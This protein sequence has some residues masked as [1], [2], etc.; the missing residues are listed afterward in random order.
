MALQK[1]DRG[2][3]SRRR[4]VWKIDSDLFTEVSPFGHFPES[5]TA[6]PILPG[7]W[8]GRHTGLKILWDVSRAGS[9]PAPGIFLSAFVPVGW[10][11]K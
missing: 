1:L 11:R 6:K 9:S 3:E 7:W 2:F 10:K 5:K 4:L 8:N